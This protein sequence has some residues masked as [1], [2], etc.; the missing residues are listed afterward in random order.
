MKI[1]AIH[2]VLQVALGLPACEKAAPPTEQ[3]GNTAV[4]RQEAFAQFDEAI[5]EILSQELLPLPGE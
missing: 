5:E 1:G 4:K 2:L 3:P